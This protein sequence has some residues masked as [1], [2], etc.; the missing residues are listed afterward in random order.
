MKWDVV[1]YS[2]LENIPEN[3]KVWD[4]IWAGTIL[5]EIS[6]TWVPDKTYNDYHLHFPIQKN[7]HL[8][9]KAWKYNYDDYLMWDWIVK[10]MTKNEII[11]YQNEIF[12]TKENITKK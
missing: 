1:F 11:A 9:S 5:W 7:P 12:N 3:L 6:I 8:L 4:F 10:W 2:H